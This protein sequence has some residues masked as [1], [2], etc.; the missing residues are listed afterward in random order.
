MLVLDSWVDTSVLISTNSV[1]EICKNGFFIPET[2]MV[3]HTGTI[4]VDRNG[5]SDLLCV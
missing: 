5:L 2:G 1:Y 3:F 4:T